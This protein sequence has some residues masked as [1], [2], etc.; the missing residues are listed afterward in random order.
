M[1]FVELFLIRW[2]AANNV[3]LAYVTN[4]VLLGSF[5]GI[6][7]GFLLAKSETDLFRLVPLTL[8][9]LTGF[10]LLFP[11]S[12]ASLHGPHQLSGG[13][14]LPALPQW[15]SLPVIF[16]LSVVIMA[17]IGQ[18]VARIF[19]CFSSLEA[20]RLDILGSIGGIAVFSA[21]AFAEMPP[22][23]W[24]LVAA[25]ALLI[26]LGRNPRYWQLAG[27]A[28]V[29]VLLGVESLSSTDYWS[30]YYKVTAVRP[31]GHR[32]AALDVSA[33]NIPHQ[34]IYPVAR[35]H[36]LEPFYF[37]PY[38]HL[39]KDSLKQVLVVGAGTGN[40]V[41]VALSEGARHIDAVEIDP[42]LQHLGVLYNPNH[43]YQS[44]RVSVHINDGRAFLQN[45]SKHYNLILFALPDSLTLLPG[46]SNLRLENYLFTLQAMQE[47]R[48]HLTSHGT[49]AMYN[50]Y[51]PF[52]LNRYA[53]TLKDA[54]GT[55]PCVELGAAL[56]ARRQAV[57]TID[58]TGVVPGCRTFW[59]GPALAP[60]TDDYPFPYLAV[61]GIPWFYVWTLALIL[62]ASFATVRWAGGPV[63]RLRPYLDLALMGGA[64]LLLE[65]K[66]IVQFALLFGTTWLVNSLVFAGVLASVFLA[67]EVVRRVRLPH[68]ALLYLALLAVL[69]VAWAVPQETVLSLSEVPRFFAATALAFAPIFV[70]NLIF[71]QRFKEIG[72]ST[73]A[74]ARQPSRGDRRRC[75]RVP[76]APNGLPVPAHRGGRPVRTCSP[77][78]VEVREPGHI[79]LRL[80]ERRL[81]GLR[82][83]ALMP[84]GSSRERSYRSSSPAL[85]GPRRS[86]AGASRREA[87]STIS[88]AI[89]RSLRFSRCEART[90]TWNASSGLR[91]PWAI[92]IPTA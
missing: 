87:R 70:A 64:F 51:E 48:A 56:A 38:H 2:T 4:F 3:Y 18:G 72:A 59:R 36:K 79:G 22:V 16:V 9:A 52:L 20:Y 80:R 65:T 75:A 34:T 10:V 88:A 31:G 46:Q 11:V 81:C 45:T 63:R 5:L 61:R 91:P 7:V 42:V 33:N 57:L 17:G 67:I 60:A 50:Y 41:A 13:F 28:A 68:P 49:F 90:R 82:L 66:N 23:V 77:V 21:L 44:R 71:A 37:Y 76:G 55:R 92:T 19:T 24:G 15:V 12:L 29:I 14:G 89:S 35:L 58:R 39:R 73:S 26:L 43:P 78:G 6:G 84:A 40:D 30:P 74:F 25:A 69:G 62:V 54:Y 86:V 32:A 1:L 53:T 8:T 47:A 85:F 83:G 27:V